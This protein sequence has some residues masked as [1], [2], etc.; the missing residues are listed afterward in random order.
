MGHII[1]EDRYVVYKMGKNGGLEQCWGYFETKREAV[2]E[3]RRS[4]SMDRWVVVLERWVATDEVT[5][6]EKAA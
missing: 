1:G 6:G 4:L 5:A 3:A 2:K